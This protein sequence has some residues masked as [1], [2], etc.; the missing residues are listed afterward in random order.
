VFEKV[1]ARDEAIKAFRGVSKRYTGAYTTKRGWLI[2]TSGPTPK[3]DTNQ[4]PEKNSKYGKRCTQMDI[5]MS[6][7]DQQSNAKTGDR[8][9]KPSILSSVGAGGS[10][11]TIDTRWQ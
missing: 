1:A 6:N 10:K 11:V 3:G 9:L 2:I 5:Q 7:E 4:Q 8:P